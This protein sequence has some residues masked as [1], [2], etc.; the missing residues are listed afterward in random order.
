MFPIK[1]LAVAGIALLAGPAVGQ[2]KKPEQS[3]K[4]SA[5]LR[6][7]LRLREPELF[8]GIGGDSWERTGFMA[9]FKAKGGGSLRMAVEV[10]TEVW[11]L[12]LP[13]D[14]TGPALAAKL[15]GKEVVVSGVVEPAPAGW[16]PAHFPTRAGPLKGYVVRVA[17]LK[18]ADGK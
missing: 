17:S 11:E 12:S 15:V 3:A 18:A 7:T 2:E 8:L 4:L 14:G 1:L 10:G 16:S 13:D 9:Q 5:E 6:G